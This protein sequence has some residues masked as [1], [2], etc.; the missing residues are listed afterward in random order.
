[1]VDLHLRRDDDLLI[2]IVLNKFH[3]TEQLTCTY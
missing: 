3:F 2:R 1:V